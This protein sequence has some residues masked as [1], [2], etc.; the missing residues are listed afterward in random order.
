MGSRRNGRVRG[1][2]LDWLGQLLCWIVAK[3]LHIAHVWNGIDFL[4]QNVGWHSERVII[5][6]YR[7]LIHGNGR[8]EY[9][10][11]SSSPG[12]TY[13]VGNQPLHL[14]TMISP[15]IFGIN[16]SLKSHKNE[17]KGAKVRKYG[18]KQTNIHIKVLRIQ[19]YNCN[20][21]LVDTLIYL[22]QACRP[23]GCHGTPRFWHIS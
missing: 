4:V 17:N 13:K 20:I 10:P 1:D 12:D 19:N 16:F 11:F 14:I 23:W 3:V 18:E 6:C 15:I 21:A 22:S 7:G 5:G 9:G 2:G 8:L